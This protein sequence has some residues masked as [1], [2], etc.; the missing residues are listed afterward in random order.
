MKSMTGFG[1]AELTSKLGR[2]TV[3]VASVNNRFL[4]FAVRLPKPYISLEAQVRDYLSGELDRGKASVNVSLDESPETPG[5]YTVN[6]AA[7]KSYARQFEQIR[8]ELK[9]NG[10]VSISDLVMLPDVVLPVRK[11]VDLDAVWKVLKKGLQ[12]ASAELVTMRVREGRAMAADMSKRLKRMTTLIGQVERRTSGS[13]EVYAEKLKRRIDD[14]MQG[15]ARDEARIEQEIAFF[16]DRTDIAEE[17]VRI[18]SHLHQYQETL[19]NKNPVGRR[20]NFVLQELNREANT[21]GSKGADFDISK[22]VI[23]LKEEI[24]KLREMVQNVE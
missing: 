1:R 17:C 8:K 5:R 7:A 19:K 16:A 24:E 4:E 21:I 14:L 20:L 23:S 11:A 2:L 6:K 13:A 12:K 15:S 9:L 3:E 18:R 10:R 22:L